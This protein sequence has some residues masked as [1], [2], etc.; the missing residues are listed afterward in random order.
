MFSHPE[1]F[2]V[3]TT[4][5]Q[6]IMRENNTAASKDTGMQVRREKLPENNREIRRFAGER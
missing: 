2:F 4:V 6:K 1:S 5:H 3:L